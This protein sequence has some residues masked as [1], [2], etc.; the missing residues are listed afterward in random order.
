MGA[1]DEAHGKNSAICFSRRAKYVGQEQNVIIFLTL[2]GE[3]FGQS[4]KC[5]RISYCGGRKVRPEGQVHSGGGCVT[6]AFSSN[7]LN[8]SRTVNECKKNPSR[9]FNYLVLFISIGSCICKMQSQTRTQ[10][11]TMPRAETERSL[12]GSAKVKEIRKN[13]N[14]GSVVTIKNISNKI[15]RR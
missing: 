9:T 3:R 15:T 14:S 4:I 13:R 8:T 7:F 6:H 10:N 12:K 5:R 1:K 2:E 11:F